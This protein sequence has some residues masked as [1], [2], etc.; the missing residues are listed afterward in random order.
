MFQ[1]LKKLRIE[2]KNKT[3]KTCTKYSSKRIWT[4]HSYC[5]RRQK[6]AA[7]DADIQQL[8]KRWKN[9]SIKLK[10]IDKYPTKVLSEI[11]RSSSIIRD[12]FDNNFTGIH[13]DDAEIQNEIKDY[14]E[15]SSRE[16]VNCKTV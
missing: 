16:K 13:V 6:V 1:F 10:Q 12:I 8:L 15:N 11:N 3:K 7:L 9:L 14:L 2:Q 5:C 4:Y